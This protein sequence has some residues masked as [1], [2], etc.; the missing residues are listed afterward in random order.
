MGLVGTFFTYIDEKTSQPSVTITSVTKH[1]DLRRSFYIVNPFGHG[2]TMIRR[3]AIINAGGYTNDYGPTEDFELWRR[4]AEEWELG[5]VP[6]PLY[7]YR[8]NPNSISHQKRD[9]QHK[10]TAKIIAEQWRKPFLYK[11]F[12]T[13]VRD[14]RY[15]RALP[16]PFAEQIYHQYIN[17]QFVIAME[18][19]ARG[20]FKT[21]L[22]TALAT[23]KLDHSKWRLLFH[24]AIGGLNRWLGIR[25]RK[26]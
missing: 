18:L 16:T 13:I 15:Y 5:M 7:W 14:A 6:E 21:G 2:T 26:K 10:F 9:I 4:L 8:I 1:L 17:E 11:G 25:E 23:V 24:P 3:D 20:K 19:F 22:I 12:R